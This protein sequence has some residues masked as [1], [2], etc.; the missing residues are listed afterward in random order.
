VRG[1]AQSTSPTSLALLG[2]GVDE[3]RRGA[4]ARVPAVHAADVAQD[5]GGRQGVHIQGGIQAVEVLRGWVGRVIGLCSLFL[6]AE[7]GGVEAYRDSERCGGAEHAGPGGH[8]PS[9]SPQSAPPALPIPAPPGPHLEEGQHVA[10]GQRHVVHA[11]HLADGVH[12]QLRHAHVNRPAGMRRCTTGRALSRAP[13]AMGPPHSA[14]ACNVR[15]QG[16]CA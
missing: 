14:R 6:L 11:A 8:P 10:V 2:R 15:A 3:G 16:E 13:W 7:G 9:S 12:G 4:A 5:V 1:P